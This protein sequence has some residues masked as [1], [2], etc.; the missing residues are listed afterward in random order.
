MRMSHKLGDDT[1]MISI[2]QEKA[3]DRDTNT[4]G[5]LWLG[6]ASTLGSLPRSGLSIVTLQ[7]CLKLMVG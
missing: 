1:G 5:G 2:E 4:S 3:F 6:L 7:V